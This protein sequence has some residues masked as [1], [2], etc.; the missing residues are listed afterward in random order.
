MS[1]DLVRY[2]ISIQNLS[3]ITGE[4]LWHE[5]PFTTTFGL[6]DIYRGKD[7]AKLWSEKLFMAVKCQ[8]ER[9]KRAIMTAPVLTVGKWETDE[10]RFFFSSFFSS[11]LSILWSD[12]KKTAQRMTTFRLAAPLSQRLHAYHGG[13]WPGDS[14]PLATT[15]REVEP[16]ADLQQIRAKW[17]SK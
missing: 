4:H 16:E 12:S 10:G 5:D 11:A 8:R 7:I 2:G 9:W 6:Q 15:Q 17:V 3:R 13:R 1:V 14:S